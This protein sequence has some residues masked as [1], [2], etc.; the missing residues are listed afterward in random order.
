MRVLNVMVV[1]CSLIVP[2]IHLFGRPRRGRCQTD[3][4]L[5][6]PAG[7]I[8][9]AAIFQRSI[10][11]IIFFLRGFAPSREAVLPG[12]TQGGGFHAKAPRASPGQA[13]AR[14]RD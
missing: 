14:R 6:R 5:R 1:K 9:R 12:L 2:V 3:V 13:P 8:W 10:Y 11:P 4:S 7:W